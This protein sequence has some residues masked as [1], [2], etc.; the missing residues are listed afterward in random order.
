MSLWFQGLL[1]FWIFL[2][3]NLITGW[4]YIRLAKGAIESKGS[5][6][7]RNRQGGYD[8]VR[9]ICVC[10]VVLEHFWFPTPSYYNTLST[11]SWVIPLLFYISGVGQR[12][13]SKG[14]WLNVLRFAWITFLIIDVN[15]LAKTVVP[16]A[17]QGDKSWASKDPFLLQPAIHQAWYCI[18]M[19]VL[20]TMVELIR[21]FH[22]LDINQRPHGWVHALA[23]IGVLAVSLIF[24]GLS[25]LVNPLNCFRHISVFFLTIFGLLVST[26]WHPP[27]IPYVPYVLLTT[28]TLY[29]ILTITTAAPTRYFISRSVTYFLIGYMQDTSILKVPSLNLGQYRSLFLILILAMSMLGPPRG[30][31]GKVDWMGLRTVNL[32]RNDHINRLETLKLSLPPFVFGLQYYLSEALVNLGV[33][34]WVKTAGGQLPGKVTRW[35]TLA[36]VGHILI[37]RT[38][39]NP[40]NWIALHAPF[41]G[42]ALY[43][44]GV[45]ARKPT[46]STDNGSSEE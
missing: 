44:M 46:G 8:I 21:R 25:G 2:V 38:L 23:T 9:V 41:F 16:T 19:V 30:V 34:Y 7:P 12:R 20:I 36:Y 33:I 1:L 14:Y 29:D 37:H 32:T 35:Y 6:P 31:I 26:R 39:P 17:F 11:Q 40:L 24:G 4:L 18:L 5:P 13:T 43:Q 42:Y 15:L 27:L 45:A 10:C 3:L 28:T 22:L